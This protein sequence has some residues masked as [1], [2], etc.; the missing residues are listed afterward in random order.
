MKI[1][2]DAILGLIEAALADEMILQSSVNALQDY[3][4]ENVPPPPEDQAASKFYDLAYDLDWF[5]PDTIARHQ[6][7]S[8]YGEQKV[9]EM[10]TQSLKD[11]RQA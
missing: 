11:L 8:L 5:E 4:W 10:L 2:R 9:R 6:D 1:D 3:I 7:S